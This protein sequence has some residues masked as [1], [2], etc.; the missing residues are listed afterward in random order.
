M[1][2]ILTGVNYTGEFLRMLESW[3]LGAGGDFI[4]EFSLGKR[5]WKQIFER[6]LGHETHGLWS[7]H[8]KRTV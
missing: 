1:H 6:V 4:R 5:N 7:F 3:K 2:N 8:E